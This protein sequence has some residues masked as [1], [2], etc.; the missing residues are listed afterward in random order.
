M[1]K[2]IVNF[3]AAAVLVSELE[4]QIAALWLEELSDA[5]YRA[6]LRVRMDKL[7][8]AQDELNF[9]AAKI[10]ELVSVADV[11]SGFGLDDTDS[12]I[13]VLCWLETQDHNGCFYDCAVAT[14]LGKDWD[15]GTPVSYRSALESVLS[16]ALG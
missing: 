14:A 15:E 12:S 11:A 2:Q 6:V 16:M 4:S 5:G 3:K 13:A 7:G 8:Q 10:A 1:E 9:A